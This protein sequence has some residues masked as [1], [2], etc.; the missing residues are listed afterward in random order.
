[1]CNPPASTNTQSI[2]DY[3]RKIE[4]T[5]IA[6]KPIGFI[7]SENSG[8]LNSEESRNLTVEII[9]HPD[10]EEALYK[11]E[12]HSHII[13]LYYF[14]NLR[15]ELGKPL[16]V[17]LKGDPSLPEVGVLAS[18]AQNRPNPIGLSVVRLLNRKGTI[19][20]VKGLDAINGSPVIDIKPY[21]PQTDS[22][23]SALTLFDRLNQKS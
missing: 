1:M 8:Q 22:V 20:Y 10:L 23:S 16:K 4:K 5:R 9:I 11:I 18:R 14:H 12:F 13:V 6:L 2:I 19:L 7:R 3:I 21:I 15:K 17:H